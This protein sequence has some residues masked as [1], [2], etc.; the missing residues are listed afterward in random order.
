MPWYGIRDGADVNTWL[1]A[2]GVHPTTKGHKLLSDAI[3]ATQVVRLD[4]SPATNP[5][6][7][8]SPANDKHTTKMALL[9]AALL[10]AAGGPAQEPRRQRAQGR[11][12]L[13]RPDGQRRQRQRH[14][15]AA[16]RRREHQRRLTAIFTYERMFTPNVGLS[17]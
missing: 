14:R 3:P 15:R 11:G 16:G 10:L 17:W 4:L 6:L 7:E 9:G 8:A 5:I 13:L 2:D 1:F 12:L